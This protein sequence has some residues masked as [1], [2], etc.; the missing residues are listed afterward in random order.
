MTAHEKELMRQLVEEE[1]ARVQPQVMPTPERP[2][3]HFTELPEDFS[4]GPIS[5]EWNFYRAEVGRLL[6]DGHEGK[7]VLIKGEEIIGIFD[8]EAEADQIRVR[9]FQ[10]Q[11]VLLKQILVQE[12]V[13]RGGGY[14]RQWRT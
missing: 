8:T 3:L 2:T 5:W 11:S 7:W 6:A 13:L 12:P 1:R 9:R 10:M 14:R 4:N